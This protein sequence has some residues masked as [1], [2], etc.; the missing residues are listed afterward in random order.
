MH[1]IRCACVW[2]LRKHLPQ[3]E[4]SKNRGNL[5]VDSFLFPHKSHTQS[6]WNITLLHD[7]TIPAGLQPRILESYDKDIRKKKKKELTL[8]TCVL[9]LFSLSQQL[10]I[11]AGCLVRAAAPQGLWWNVCLLVYLPVSLSP[12]VLLPRLRLISTAFPVTPKKWVGKRLF[13]GKSKQRTCR[14]LG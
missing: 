13:W 11:P 3:T 4:V 7:C 6:Q 12:C 2:Y 9:S 14:Q 1:F 8:H 10:K 5:S